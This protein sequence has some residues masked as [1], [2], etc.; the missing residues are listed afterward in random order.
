MRKER[1]SPG[2]EGEST[3]ASK[4]RR[5]D[6]SRQQPGA[7]SAASKSEKSHSKPSEL[8][9]AIAPNLPGSIYRVIFHTDGSKSQPYVNAAI[10]DLVGVSSEEAIANPDLLPLSIH[11]DDREQFE[12]WV[13]HSRATLAPFDHEFRLVTT[14]G[15]IRWVRDRARY[16]RLEN[17]DVVAD[18]IVIDISDQKATEQVLHHQIH[19]ER[20]L[21]QIASHIRYSLDL[22]TIL[23]TTVEEVRRFLKADRVLIYRFAP[24][25]GCGRVV[26]EDCAPEYSSLLGWEIGDAC[27]QAA[28]CIQPFVSGKLRVIASLQAADLPVAYRELLTTFEV[29]SQLVIPIVHTCNTEPST[30]PASAVDQDL[31][32]YRQ[33]LWGM[34]VVHQCSGD[35]P[36]QTWEMQALKRLET[37]LV[38]AI[39]QAEL[40]NRLKQFNESLESQVQERTTQLQQALGFEAMLKRITE[41]IRDSLDENLILQG[42]VE[43][44]AVL[45]NALSCNASH[46]D[47]EQRT[48]TIAYEYTQHQ[49]K[50]EGIAV[51]MDTLPELYAPLLQGQSL[52]FCLLP[53][54]PTQGRSA[55]LACPIATEKEILGDL[56]LIHQADRGFTRQEVQLVQQVANQCAIALRQS[57]L[58]AAAKQQ[59]DELARLNRLKD[60]FL[61]TISHELRTPLSSIKMSVQLLE[62]LLPDC[63]ASADEASDKP[64]KTKIMGCLNILK[65][66]CDREI[67]LINDLL[68]LQHLE[69]GTQPFIPSQM[70]LQDWVP[71]VVET[72][73]ERCREHQQTLQVD[74]PADLPPITTDLFMFNRVLGELLTNA[75]KFTPAR[76]TITVAVRPVT[77]QTGTTMEAPAPSPE[78]SM[79]QLSVTNTGVTIPDYELDH[80][81]SKFYRIS[82][83]DPWKHGGT[84]LGLA[85][86]KQMMTYLG[87]AIAV[88]SQD[89]A[90]SFTLEL[91]VEAHV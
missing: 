60:D 56:W 73:A 78:G 61:S 3:M 20:L 74:I 24:R 66:E 90:T 15:G 12:R 72:F 67:S 17:G 30:V 91:P 31:E 51:Q 85:L 19:Q 27:D 86:V 21:E 33:H 5:A 87:G 82:S 75:Y 58:Y 37:Q 40:Y 13:A 64:P 69:A 22:R 80:V 11:P 45:F 53:S 63:Q 23:Q 35:R 88:S 29:R 34:L 71:Q 14:D 76:E 44:L 46:Y 32:H 62:M 68:T 39:Q 6:Q 79:I 65:Q 10:A 25:P 70:Q 36:W 48:A 89:N 77:P 1:G 26:V 42:A 28:T 8:L 54:N 16:Y 7:R 81:F 83:R 55:V 9:E 38:V 43:E 59:V 18:G 57:R 50:T 41:R 4:R 49:A 2:S 47:L 52:Q 84:G